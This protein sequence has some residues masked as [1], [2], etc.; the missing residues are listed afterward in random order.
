MKDIGLTDQQFQLQGPND[1]CATKLMAII[2]IAGLL[3][4]LIASFI[5]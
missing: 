5:Y 4:I 2:I 1:G 3:I